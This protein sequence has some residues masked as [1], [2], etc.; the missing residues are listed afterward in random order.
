[1]TK[2]ERENRMRRILRKL[3]CRLMKSRR[4]RALYAV[5]RGSHV[6]YE[7]DFLEGVEVCTVFR[8]AATAREI[9][10]AKPKVR[11]QLVE[12][13]LKKLDK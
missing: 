1:M 13:A 4:R 2:K 10:D 7:T 6:E 5:V 3:G 11:V 9:G 12:A 8:D